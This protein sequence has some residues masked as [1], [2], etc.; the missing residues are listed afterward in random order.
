VTPEIHTS[1]AG[2]FER[3]MSEA[4]P[5]NE[6]KPPKPSV[7]KWRRRA[8]DYWFAFRTESPYLSRIATVLHSIAP[9]SASV[10]RSFQIQGDAHRSDRPNLS[11]ENEEAEVFIRMNLRALGGGEKVDP[12][13][14]EDVSE[15]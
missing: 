3:F 15:E 12:D 2:E 1:V 9:T 10:E 8:V 5:F 4:V 14:C 7:N 13:A 11:H 6:V